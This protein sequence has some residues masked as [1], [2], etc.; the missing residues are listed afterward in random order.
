[1]KT[2][3]SYGDFCISY[4][5]QVRLLLE[6]AQRHDVILKE[7]TC[8]NCSTL[9]RLDCNRKAFRCDK[10]FV[11][12]GSR[13]KRKRSCNFLVSCFKGTWFERAHL[14]IETNLK[15]VFLF[16]QKAFSY[17]FV[18]LELKLTDK[19]INDWCSF[20]REVIIDWVVR[21]MPKII[22]LLLFTALHRQLAP[23]ALDHIGLFF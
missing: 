14:D 18:R 11:S 13:G 23:P 19:T 7:K 20:C 2:F 4:S 8:P 16:L 15:F 21:R 10:T 3:I 12:R 22:G 1:M 17:E 6:F 9:C 5:G